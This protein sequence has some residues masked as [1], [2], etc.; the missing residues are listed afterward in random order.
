MF[1]ARAPRDLAVCG[2]LT[3]V[4]AI[5]I[6]T[7]AHA[8]TYNFTGGSVQ[9]TAVIRGTSTSVLEPGTS[10]VVLPLGG[11]FVDFDPLA[12]P[13]GTITGLE[14]IPNG[15]FIL[16]LDQTVVGLNVIEI[17]GA[18]LVDAPPS[19]GAV[20]AGNS[21]AIDTIISGTVT[22]VGGPPPATPISS[23]QSGTTGIMGL[24]ADTLTLGMFGI[25]V[26]SFNSIV[27]PGVVIDVKA[28]FSFIGVVPEPTTAT[29]LGLGLCGLAAR[30]ASRRRH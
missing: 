5:L 3:L 27:T 21:F 18:M 4:A 24:S 15:N 22:G 25:N 20:S 9:L 17:S 30:G 16:D 12:G 1:R 2:L 29:L 14:L 10:P 6:P 7:I 13:Y 19:T 11:S 8:T 23:L 28:D 26:A